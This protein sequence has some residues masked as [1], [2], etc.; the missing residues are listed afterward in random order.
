MKLTA[1][2]AAAGLLLITATIHA[3][4]DAAQDA[5]DP[6]WTWDLTDLYQSDDDWAAALE[7]AL[8]GLEDL[9]ALKG[10]L[11]NGPEA[12]LTAL[13]T[14]NQWFLK[15]SRVFTYASL[16]ADENLGDPRG[17]ER[18]QQAQRMF[19]EYQQASAWFQ[20]EMMA[21]GRETLERYIDELPELR[22]HRFNIEDALRYEPHTLG[23]EAEGVIAAAG[24]MQASPFNIYGLLANSEI[25]W[26]TITLSTGEEAFI[27]SQGYSRHR[28][29]R[30]REDR[31][32]VFDAFWTTWGEFKGTAGQSLSAH[33]TSQLF[34]TNVRNYEDTL[35]RNLFQ[36]NLPRSVYDAL[37]KVTNENLSSLHRYLELKARVLGLEDM[38]Y[39]DIYVSSIQYSRGDSTMDT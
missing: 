35:T 1:C 23:D 14:N 11:S 36:D 9:R 32:A 31:K 22:T 21:L 26:Q 13:Q 39:E 27:N 4:D 3:Q 8:A 38:G 18:R 25:P 12:L 34:T 37:V 15:G 29:S 33:L 17:Q 24:L 30:V 10:T 20:P 19:S 7:E 16:G 28:T 5:P 2:L 6:R